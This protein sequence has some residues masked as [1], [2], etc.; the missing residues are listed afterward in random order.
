MINRE[1]C[2]EEYVLTVHTVLQIIRL[3]NDGFI[4]KD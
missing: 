3:M 1:H 4:H 2:Q